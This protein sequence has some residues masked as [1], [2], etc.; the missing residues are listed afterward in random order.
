MIGWQP[1]VEVW[2]LVAGLVGLGFYAVRVIGPKAVAAGE[3]VITPRQRAMWV[4]AVVVLWS[5]SDWPVHD[6]AEERLYFVHMVQHLALTYAF[7]ALV[8]LA[9]PTWLARLVIGDGWFAGS[10]LRRL[11]HPVAAGVL[12]NAVVVFT[13]WPAMV[14]ASVESGPLHYL[15][16]TVLVATALL[17]W[18]PVCGPLPE[19]RLTKPGQMIYLF[20]MSI[21]PTIPAAWLTFADGAVYDVYDRPLRLWSISVTTDQQLA[22]ILMKLGAGLY[23][24]GLIVVLFFRWYAEQERDDRA[25]RV[26]V[27]PDDVLTWDQVQAELETIPPGPREP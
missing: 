26:V 19:L 11:C 16:H 6:I 20:L 8:L 9:T 14:N 2:L 22:G 4:A 1:H 24:W 3:P 7:P 27:P 12:F 13:H 18:T 23:L 5:A 15:L 25:T 21:V 10:G 17:M